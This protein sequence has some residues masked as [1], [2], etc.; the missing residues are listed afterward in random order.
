MI[1]RSRSRTRSARPTG[2]GGRGQLGDWLGP[3][4]PPDAPGDARTDGD[5]VANAYVARSADVL[6]GT[7]R[8]LR[9]KDDAVRYEELARAVRTAFA[10]EFVTPG[11]RMS[12]DAQTAYALALGFVM[13]PTERQRRGA[14]R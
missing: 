9:E 7:A 11:R 3:A 12:S 5:L 14:A 1:R 6:A 8:L 2:A 13:L 4:A 10:D